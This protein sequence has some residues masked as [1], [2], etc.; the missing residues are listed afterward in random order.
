MFYLLYHL[1]VFIFPVIDSDENIMNHYFTL[2]IA[3]VSSDDVIITTSL[4]SENFIQRSLDLSNSKDSRSVDTWLMSFFL[5]ISKEY[6]SILKK[7]KYQLKEIESKVIS[8]TENTLLYEIIGIN[9]GLLYF[10]KAI[11]GNTDILKHIEDN[12]IKHGLDEL[13]SSMLRDA[14][15]EHLQAIDLVSKFKQ[16]IDRLSSMISNVINN[17]VNTVM[18]RLTGW[19]ITLT[20]PTILAALWGMNLALAFEDNPLGFWIVLGLS[21]IITILVYLFLKFTKNI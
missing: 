9:K 15:I 18:K 7:F 8:S 11:E 21:L 1:Y 3:I 13:E 16:I 4:A 10:E 17:N 2:P 5:T 20:F 12:A 14:Q 19:T 6:T